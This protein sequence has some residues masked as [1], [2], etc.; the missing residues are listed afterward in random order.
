MVVL[1]SNITML[2][3]KFNMDAS[4]PEKL[5]TLALDAEKFPEK[6]KHVLIMAVSEDL[7]HIV[8][9]SSP[10]PTIVTLGLCKLWEEILLSNSVLVE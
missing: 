2:P 10:I 5:R 8:N 6:Y 7:E 9:Y 4:I 1:M 3:T